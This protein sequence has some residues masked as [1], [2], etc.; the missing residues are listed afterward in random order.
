MS[1]IVAESLRVPEVAAS[2]RLKTFDNRRSR[3]IYDHAVL[4]QLRT[5]WRP[6][7]RSLAEVVLVG[8]HAGRPRWQPPVH[9][10]KRASAA[11]T[12]RTPIKDRFV[13]SGH[14]AEVA[15]QILSIPHKQTARSDSETG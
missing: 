9:S 7:R 14:S 2:W 10:N 11:Q 6:E 8:R 15:K 3:N 1:G 5:I 12:I 4:R 13:C